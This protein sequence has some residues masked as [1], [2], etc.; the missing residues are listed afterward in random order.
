MLDW[1]YAHLLINHFPIILTYLGLAAVIVAL[2]TRRR[3]A[4]LYALATLTLAGLAVYPA[5]LTG[6]QAAPIMEKLWYVDERAVDDH[7]KAGEIAQWILLGMGALSAYGWWRMVRA[8]PVA[9]DAA[10]RAAREL[11]VVLRVAVLVAALAGSG[12]IAF[13]AFEGG[14]IVHKATRL[15]QPPSGASDP[16]SP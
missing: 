10:E 3:S 7:E 4:W 15:A 13:A 16:G 8:R 2:A 9:G 1:P 5:V 6:S 14:M 11:P 12:A